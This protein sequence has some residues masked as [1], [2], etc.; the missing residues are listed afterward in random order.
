MTNMIC[1]KCQQEKH[2]TCYDRDNPVLECGH[3]QVPLLPLERAREAQRKTN[4]QV[5]DLMS[6]SDLSEDQALAAII[7]RKREERERVR[8][9]EE[10]RLQQERDAIPQKVLTKRSIR[11]KVLVKNVDRKIPKHDTPIPWNTWDDIEDLAKML[12]RP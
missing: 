8:I 5:V 1:Q 2:I 3:I 11:R 9:Q 10:T 4:A 12:G 6:R 7:E